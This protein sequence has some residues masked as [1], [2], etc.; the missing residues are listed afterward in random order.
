MKATKNLAERKGHKLARVSKNTLAKSSGSP[1]TIPR[2]EPIALP[3]DVLELFKHLMRLLYQDLPSYKKEM[4]KLQKESPELY[5]RYLFGGRRI[6]EVKAYIKVRVSS[7]DNSH[8]SSFS[9]F[10]NSIKFLQP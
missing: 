4:A 3:P 2:N 6:P 10:R 9:H 7:V 8:C 1:S 5:R